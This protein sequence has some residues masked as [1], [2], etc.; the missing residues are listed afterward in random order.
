MNTRP[1][2]AAMI[3]VALA[4][5]E[6]E[7]VVNY[8]TVQSFSPARGSVMTGYSGAALDEA[9]RLSEVRQ[10]C[11]TPLA[12]WEEQIP[13]FARVKRLKYKTYDAHKN[14]LTTVFTFVGSS[15]DPS[16]ISIEYADTG[17]K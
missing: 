12:E 8:E 9:T 10:S 7:K 16:L 13:F 2:I 15:S 4:G 11:G 5:C 14:V 3:V 17:Q 6:R 1:I